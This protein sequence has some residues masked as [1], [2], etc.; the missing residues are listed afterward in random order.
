MHLFQIQLTRQDDNIGKTGIEFQCFRIGNVELCG[1]MHLLS[2]AVGIVHS[3][4]IGRNDRWNFRL[5][6]RIDNLAHQRQVFPINNRIDGQIALNTVLTTKRNDLAQI[7][8]RKVI[9]RARTHIQSFDTEIDRIGSPVDSR[10]QW[11]VRTDRRHYFKIFLV[12]VLI[13]LLVRSQR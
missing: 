12:Q 13:H 3:C 7:V 8:C 11:F 1:K 5:L 9:G 2:D 6:R 4:H 10:H